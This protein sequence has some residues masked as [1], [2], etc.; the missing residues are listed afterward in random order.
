MFPNGS[1]LKRSIKEKAVF[2]KY[3]F[4]FIVR[5]LSTVSQTMYFDTNKRTTNKMLMYVGLAYLVYEYCVGLMR[6]NVRKGP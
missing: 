1:R 6:L 2:K 5:F 3:P 4:V